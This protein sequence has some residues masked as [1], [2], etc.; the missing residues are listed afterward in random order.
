MFRVIAL[1]SDCVMEILTSVPRATIC[2]WCQDQG[3][4]P[5]QVTIQR[6]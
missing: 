1:F 2:A 5:Y 3:E 4:A 6:V